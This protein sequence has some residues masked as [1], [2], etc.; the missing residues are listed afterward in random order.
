MFE[1]IYIEE[2]AKDL[3]LTQE[4]LERFSN[5]TKI[6][7]HR[8]TEIFNRKA[9]NF[10]LQKLKPTLILANKFDKLILPTPEGYGIG[11][12]HNYYFSHMLNCIYD[13]RYCFL[14]GMYLRTKS[15]FP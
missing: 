11:A 13:C 7:C 4:I 15:G 12:R 9:Q 3:P 10:R 14:Q 1:T 6:P 8:Y 2:G 5:A